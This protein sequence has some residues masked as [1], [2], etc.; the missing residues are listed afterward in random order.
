N[1]KNLNLNDKILLQLNKRS[2]NF[3]SSWLKAV[4]FTL[5]VSLFGFF[6][7]L[8]VNTFLIDSGYKYEINLNSK[9]ASL[10]EILKEWLRFTFSFDLRSYQNYESNG[11]LLFVFFFFKIFIGYGVYQ[12]IAAFRKHSK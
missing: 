12:T 1:D 8:F 3:G 7:L 10:Q 5:K 6:V 11:F 9:W 2:N 4:W